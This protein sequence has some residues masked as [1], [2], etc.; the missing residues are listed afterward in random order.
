MLIN[1]YHDNGILRFESIPTNDKCGVPL[2][3]RKRKERNKLTKDDI[4]FGLKLFSVFCVTRC[5]HTAL[6]MRRFSRLEYGA[7][8]HQPL[9]PYLL[10]RTLGI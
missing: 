2:V 4:P 7:K 3:V 5:L 8:Q 6:G 9:L 10:I 1:K